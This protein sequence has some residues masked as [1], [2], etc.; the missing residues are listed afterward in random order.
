MDVIA[1]VDLSIS[2]DFAISFDAVRLGC[3]GD[4]G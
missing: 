1:N 4:A 2:F 3:D